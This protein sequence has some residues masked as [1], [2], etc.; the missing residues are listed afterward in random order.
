MP[1]KMTVLFKWHMGP[2]RIFALALLVTIACWQVAVDREQAA[3][4]QTFIR[5]TQ[6]Y[7]QML[8]RR[9]EAYVSF[10]TDLSSL[11]TAN[12]DEAVSYKAFASFVRNA[13]VIINYPGTNRIGYLPLVPAAGK[14]AYEARMRR[15]GFPEYH[16]RAAGLPIY[17]PYT[18]LF[19]LD[20]QVQRALLGL[21]PHTRPERSAAMQQARD[22]N[23]VISTSKLASL[24]YPSTQSSFIFYAPVYRSDR[25]RQTTVQRRQALA[26]YV[27]AAF[28]ADRLLYNAWGNDLDRIATVRFYDGSSATAGNLL[29]DSEGAKGSRNDC[30][31]CLTHTELIRAAG[32]QW[33]LEFRARPA[34][35][36]AG[37]QALPMFVL[38]G[39]LVTSLLL[40]GITILRNGRL[41]LAQRQQEQDQQFRSLFDQNPDAV[42]SLSPDGHF[43]NANAATLALTGLSLKAL[44]ATTFQQFI[45]P[46]DLPAALARFHQAAQGAP[47][48]GEV[49]LIDPAGKRRELA[50]TNLPILI[51]NQ[52]IGVF[53]IAKDITL[54]KRAEAQS[55]QMRQ[56][57]DAVI[58]NL[59]IGM[60]AKEAKTLRF[61]AWNKGN[62]KISGIS[63]DEAIGKTDYDFF[64]REEA[65]YYTAADRGVLASW[66]PLDI[67]EEFIQTRDKG[68]RLLHTR[69]VPFRMGEDAYLLGISE[70]I[71]EGRRAAKELHETKQMLEKVLDNI[72]QR[73]FWKDLDLVYL[74][75]NQL[76]IEDTEMADPVGKTD[77]DMPWKEHADRFRA[78]DM[79]VITRDQAKLNCEESLRR[80]DGSLVWLR[81][82][83]IPL[84]DQAGKVIGVLGTYEDITL[85]KQAEEALYRAHMQLEERVQDRTKELRKEIEI[86]REAEKALRESQ[87]TLQKIIETMPVG[88]WIAD[89]TGHIIA[90]NPEAQRI[91]GGA[92][93]DGQVLYSM[94]KA[95]Q[96]RAGRQIATVDALL[97]QAAGQGQ[98][99]REEV[100]DIEAFDGARKK[101]LMSAYPL[102]DETQQLIGA[103][104]LNQDISDRVQ[105]EEELRQLSTHLQTV[106]EDER[107]RIAREI[108]DELGGVLAAV[109]FDLSTPIRSGDT[110]YDGLSRRNQDIVRLVDN[111]IVALRR[112]MSDLR[113]SVLD[114]LGLWAA[115][116]WQAQEF[117]SRMG[118]PTTFKLK[119]EEVHLEPNRA[120]AL[121]RMTQESLTNV[122]KHAQ[123]TR[124]AIT[125]T[126]KD[127]KIIIHIRD[128]GRGICK[129]DLARAKSFGIKGMNERARAFS[130]TVR[131]N[132]RPGEGTTVCI[133]FPMREPGHTA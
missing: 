80:S 88:I 126:T 41:Q 1:K 59:P 101:V 127:H 85:Q 130:G 9:I 60:F 97:A 23:Q 19:P 114:D 83:K 7:R 109:K 71:T 110:G 11:F 98:G 50:T 90:A 123:A 54:T 18:Y 132:G 31:Q 32:R 33:R 27:F 106:R 86:R 112:I 111:A 66:E 26:G 44:K 92:G 62:E 119:G 4:Q 122:A 96:G 10:L 24:V 84:H 29:Y 104:A 2:L 39:G 89:R 108:H 129:A 6:M 40:T 20:D 52:V 65:D 47:S 124:V 105:R 28:R 102:L 125:A 113:P 99:I 74:G 93:G 34:F 100:I 133:K 3:R 120:T 49:T 128:N 25:P 67:P 22:L 21:D 14:A 131:I 79:E 117:E 43:I 16:I 94:H 70:D 121:F 87:A 51:N 95:R 8:E 63:H 64:P 58:D 73:V 46:E 12:E 103:I 38:V 48:V 36:Q 5:A 61:I 42:Y 17:F 69:K 82:S 72:P 13:H 15:M 37:G 56:F 45:V 57:L 107:T 115:L 76:W 78:E 91:W 81:T 118:I 35:Y 75:G 116:E 53:G 55:R 30:R 77:F 68:T